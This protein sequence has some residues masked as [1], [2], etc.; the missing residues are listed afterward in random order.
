MPVE[1]DELDRA[2]VRL[3][4]RRPASDWMK[5]QDSVITPPATC[6]RGTRSS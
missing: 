6:A 5:M 2:V 4:C 3:A 1:P